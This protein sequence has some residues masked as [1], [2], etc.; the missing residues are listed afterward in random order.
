M[1]LAKKVGVAKQKAGGAKRKVDG[2]ASQPS[3]GIGN[4]ARGQLMVECE[5]FSKRPNTVDMD[6]WHGQPG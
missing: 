1:N 3:V 6:T 2:A 5:L 4:S